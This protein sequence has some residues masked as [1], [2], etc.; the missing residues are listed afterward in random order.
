MTAFGSVS[1]HYQTIYCYNVCPLDSKVP[2]CFMVRHHMSIDPI[3]GLLSLFVT[4]LSCHDHSSITALPWIRFIKCC[5][6]LGKRVLPLVSCVCSW[7]NFFFRHLSLIQSSIS[8]FH[9]ITQVPAPIPVEAHCLRKMARPKFH[10]KICHRSWIDHKTWIILLYEWHRIWLPGF[11]VSCG[12][13]S[14]Y[15][16]RF[17]CFSLVST[18]RWY[19]GGG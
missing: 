19:S 6:N 8:V 18:V 5:C 11:K 1:A 2:T 15:L 4:K 12:S 13:G 7:F 3:L 9:M 10:R 14:S 17:D 16:E